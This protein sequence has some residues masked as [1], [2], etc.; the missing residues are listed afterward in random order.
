MHIVHGSYAGGRRVDCAVPPD[1][2]ARPGAPRP[3]AA[4]A[5]GAV[6]VLTTHQATLWAL[7]RSGLAPWPA[8]SLAPTRPLGVPALASAAFWGGVWWVALARLLP[9]HPA[10]PAMAYYGRAALLGAVLP[11]VAGA[12]LLAVGRGQPLGATPPAIAA[13]SAALVNGAW[14]ITAAAV[15]R[16][17]HG[18]S[19]ADGPVRRRQPGDRQQHLT[20]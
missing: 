14:G 3:A 18:Q 6:A 9:R 7:H 13:L 2:L 16:R 1:G 15:L 20:G 10:A 12:L 11:N 4:F 19:G 5:A 17:L 8:Y